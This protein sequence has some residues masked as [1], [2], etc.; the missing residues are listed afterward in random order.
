MHTDNA[1]PPSGFP[2]GAKKHADYR[3]GAH[4]AV[5]AQQHETASLFSSS[6]ER[7]DLGAF[8][9]ASSQSL[10]QVCRTAML[11]QEIIE[12]LIRQLL[13]CLHAF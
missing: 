13:K 10:F 7:D 1:G 5:S 11:S 2:Q 8:A 12:G 9:G 3:G 4:E 6:L